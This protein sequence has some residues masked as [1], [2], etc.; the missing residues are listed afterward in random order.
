MKIFSYKKIFGILLT[1]IFIGFLINYFNPKGI[2]L[3][4][5]TPEINWASDSLF[6]NLETVTIE[7]DSITSIPEEINVNQSDTNSQPEISSK[8][9]ED[10]I[11]PPTEPIKTEDKKTGTV[12]A[13]TEPKAVTLDQAYKLFNSGVLF[14]DAR[15]EADYVLGHISNSINIPFDDFDNHKQKLEKLSIEKPMVVYCAGT[16][17]DLSHLLA[18]LLFEKGYKQVYVFFGGWNE[19]IEANYLIDKSAE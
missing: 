8:K 5:E 3:I 16:D 12:V 4:R 6:N 10:F 19:W 14:I 7:D 18:N 11:Q 2:S 15:D 17:C 9:R 1:S 13:F